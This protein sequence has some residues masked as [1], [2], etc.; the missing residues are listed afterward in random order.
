MMCVCVHARCVCVCRA[1]V[2]CY[3]QIMSYIEKINISMSSVCI[4][5]VYSM[6][7]M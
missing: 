7:G 5:N 3:V 6:P 2:L 1:S 4:I